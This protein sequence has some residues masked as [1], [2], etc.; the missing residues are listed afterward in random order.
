MEPSVEEQT[1]N[2]G[3]LCGL[4]GTPKTDIE[5][6]PHITNDIKEAWLKGWEKGSVEKHIKYAASLMGKKGGSVKSEKKT[7]AVRQN[8][9]KGGRPRKV[10]I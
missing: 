1:E 3:Y 8:G 9:K 5:N 10:R 2:I 6:W 7:L 4:D